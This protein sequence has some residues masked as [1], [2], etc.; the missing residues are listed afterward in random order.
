MAFNA[1]SAI[2]SIGETIIDRVIP[3]KNAA[4]IAKETLAR[5]EQ[6][7]ELSIIA[8]Q[9]EINK[10]EAAHKS[11]FVAGWRPA[12]GWICAFA[13]AYHFICAPILDIWLEIPVIE[14]EGLYPILMGMLGL[15]GMRSFEKMKGVAREK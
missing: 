13:L 2:F 12:V 15:G 8:G 6:Q 1:I 4:R 7:G 5:M 11:I 9:L 3:D 14:V 10:I